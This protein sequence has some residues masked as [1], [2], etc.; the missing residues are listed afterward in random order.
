MFSYLVYHFK[1]KKVKTELM[2]KIGVHLPSFVL[3]IE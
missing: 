1:N 2:K 3:N